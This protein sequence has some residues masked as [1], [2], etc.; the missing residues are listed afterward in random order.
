MPFE[1][2]NKLAAGVDHSKRKFMTQALISEL[3]AVDP[4]TQ[5]TRL[6]KII[7]KLLSN[8]EDGDNTAIEHVFS[9]VEGKPAQALTG[10]DGEKLIESITVT[11]VNP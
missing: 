5:Q 10:P 8:A 4:K 9:R 6:R 11:F 2:G 1:K 3:N 7:D